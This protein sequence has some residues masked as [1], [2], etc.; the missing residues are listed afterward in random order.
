MAACL[1]LLVENPELHPVF[2]AP[3]RDSG[4]NWPPPQFKFAILGAGFLPQDEKV[5]A[6][7]GRTR[8]RPDP[9]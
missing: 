5:R 6:V 8:S 3:S 4:S 2:A 1:T 9:P 7:A